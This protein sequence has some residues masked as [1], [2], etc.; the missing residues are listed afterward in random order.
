MLRRCTPS[1]AAWFGLTNVPLTI[2][3]QRLCGSQA[4]LD[5]QEMAQFTSIISVPRKNGHLAKYMAGCWYLG[6]ERGKG[7]TG[8]EERRYISHRHF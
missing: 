4:P 8:R 2:M 1:P 7:G 5:C 6:K 3:R